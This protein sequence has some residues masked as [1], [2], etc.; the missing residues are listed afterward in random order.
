M[1]Q[2]SR[3]LDLWQQDTVILEHAYGSEV[4]LLNSSNKAKLKQQVWG[5]G[6]LQEFKNKTILSTSRLIFHLNSSRTV[7]CINTVQAFYWGSAVCQNIQTV[8]WQNVCF[9]L[10]PST[11]CFL[12][13]QGRGNS[14]EALIKRA[15]LHNTKLPFKKP[16]VFQ[17][18][19][20][21]L[22]ILLLWSESRIIAWIIV[23]SW[24]TAKTAQI[25]STAN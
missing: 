23:K 2:Q 17:P 18:Q 12:E 3:N 1:Q 13:P 10:Y 16:A 5:G 4:S 7:A 14:K 19:L 24:C 20:P 22:F 11:A 9:N 6:S 21:T 15:E 8:L 25:K